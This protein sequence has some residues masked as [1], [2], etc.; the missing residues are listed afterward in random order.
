MHSCSSVGFVTFINRKVSM[1]ANVVSLF[2][3]QP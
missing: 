2:C 1:Q 3:S